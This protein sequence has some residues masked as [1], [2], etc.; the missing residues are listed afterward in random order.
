MKFRVVIEPDEDGI[1]VAE[2]PSLPGCISQGQTRAE[3]VANIQDAIGGYLVSLKK[4]G[5]PVPWPITEE[6]VEVPV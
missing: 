6:V 4:H 5:D 1:F 2:C 3:A